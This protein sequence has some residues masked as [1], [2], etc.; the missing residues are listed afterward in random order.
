MA[1]IRIEGV[2]KRVVLLAGVGLLPFSTPS[3]APS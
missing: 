1:N 2:A 3:L